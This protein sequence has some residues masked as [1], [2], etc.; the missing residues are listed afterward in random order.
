MADKMFGISLGD[1]RIKWLLVVILAAI[2]L[3][4]VVW[5]GE[6]PPPGSGAAAA[7][8]R[9]ADGAQRSPPVSG[10]TQGSTAIKSPSKT[11]GKVPGNISG[12]QPRSRPNAAAN[13]E[14]ELETTLKFNPF[15]VRP[16]LQRQI[17]GSEAAIAERNVKQSHEELAQKARASAMQQRL[18]EFQG[19]KVSVVLRNSD[20]GAAVALIGGRLV[21]EGEVVDGIRI[22]SISTDGVVVEAVP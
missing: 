6:A 3:A 12:K 21:R 17:S 19:M 14:D 16:A 10:K 5:G 22:L 13:P 4:V 15:A 11:A 9:Q 20:G 8:A 2:L 18:S 1:Q 7:G